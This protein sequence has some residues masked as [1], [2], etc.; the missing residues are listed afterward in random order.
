MGKEYITTV[1]AGLILGRHVRRVQQLI[2][3]SVL[4]AGQ[5]TGS[6]SLESVLKYQR[7]IVSGEVRRGP[8]TKKKAA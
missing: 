2:K 4:E 1:A 7:A 3:E 5:F 8:K 6:V